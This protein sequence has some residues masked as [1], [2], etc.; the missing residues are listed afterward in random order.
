M[1]IGKELIVSIFERGKKFPCAVETLF[2][3][4]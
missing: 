3:K 1:K 4:I 2:N